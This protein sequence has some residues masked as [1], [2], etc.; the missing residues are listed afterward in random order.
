MDPDGGKGGKT[1]QNRAGDDER[2]AGVAIT[3]P[4][5]QRGGEHVEEEER[6]GQSAH[7]VV[8]GVEVALNQG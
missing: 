6:G 1:P 8:G 4:A 5:G 3:Q 7:L 2:L